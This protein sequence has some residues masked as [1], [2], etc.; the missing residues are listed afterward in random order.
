MG[1]VHFVIQYQVSKKAYFIKDCGN[2]TG[3]F[4]KV[5]H[6][7]PLEHGFMFTFGESHMIVSLAKQDTIE[8]RFFGGPKQ[9]E[10]LYVSTPL[11]ALSISTTE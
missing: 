11:L 2:G 8:I 3:T 1:S 4:V 9:D 6:E 10:M 5:E 7:L